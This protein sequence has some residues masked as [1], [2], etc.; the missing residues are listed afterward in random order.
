MDIQYQEMPV[1]ERQELLAL[2]QDASWLVYTKDLDQ[3]MKAYQ[4][5]QYVLGAY[6][7]DRLVGI[8]RAITDQTTIIYIQDIIVLKAYQ[9]NKIGSTLLSF[10][11][12][13]FKHVRQKV[14]LT[15]DEH[16]TRLF[17]TKNKFRACDNGVIV[18]YARFD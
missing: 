13:R 5:S 1:V 8:L 9:K 3:L 17:Y 12:E 14:L 15:D 2:Y 4:N 16:R 6:D 7:G 18:A 11:L 10:T